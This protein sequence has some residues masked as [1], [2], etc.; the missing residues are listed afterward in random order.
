MLLII[1]YVTEINYAYQELKIRRNARLKEL[2][3]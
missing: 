1:S 3:E 2:Y